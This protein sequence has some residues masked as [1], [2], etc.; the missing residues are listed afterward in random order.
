MHNL[1]SS[2]GEYSLSTF[3]I[4][5]DSKDENEQLILNNQS[6]FFHEFIH[7]IHDLSTVFGLLNLANFCH[8]LTYSAKEIYKQKNGIINLPITNLP[9]ERLTNRDLFSVYLGENNFLQ[10]HQGIK[11]IDLIPNGL[12]KGFEELPIIEV[13]YRIGT[14]Q[15][16]KNFGT[17]AIL[18]SAA[19]LFEEHIFNTK[20]LPKFPYSSCIDISN[21][22]LGF[23]LPREIL[24]L[25]IEI[26]LMNT[27]PGLFFIDFLNEIKTWKKININEKFILNFF[28]HEI[29]FNGLFSEA[30]YN[31]QS[32]LDNSVNHAI[33]MF[34]IILDRK[35]F[36][37][38]ADL[39][40]TKIQLLRAKRSKDFNFLGSLLSKSPIQALN[41]L[42]LLASEVGAPLVVNST[43]KFFVIS[44]NEVKDEVLL[45]AALG[46]VY[47]T[48]VMGKKSCELYPIC[49]NFKN[50]LNP[51]NQCN[52]EPWERSKMEKLC[53]YS[54]LW[55]SYTFDKYQF[56]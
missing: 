40:A 51:D 39:I 45:F 6:T 22:I 14:S 35:S 3:K 11:G 46:S 28:T 44:K 41:S 4:F 21:F 2:N 56:K 25:I 13:S 26:S 16:K 31:H 8:N 7:F 50:E 1:K 36:N 12:I 5:I 33:T 49:L 27:Y 43:G 15:V 30:D 48:L 19:F 29:K 55:K 10:N 47:E 38:A 18:E 54:Q 52:S 34:N 32:L 37:N 24:F 20:N 9:E 42:D 23:T 53:Y 17:L